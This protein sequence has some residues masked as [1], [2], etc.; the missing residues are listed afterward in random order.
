MGSLTWTDTSSCYRGGEKD[1]QNGCQ[2]CFYNKLCLINLNIQGLV[3]S[4]VLDYF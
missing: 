3:W 4:Q 2:P 1:R